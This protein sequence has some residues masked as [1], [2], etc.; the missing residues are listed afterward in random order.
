[1]VKSTLVTLDEICMN[2]AIIHVTIP[3]LMLHK[4]P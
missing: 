3:P 1:M 2:E 4:D